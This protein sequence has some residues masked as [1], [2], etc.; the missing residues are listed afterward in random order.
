MVVAYKRNSNGTI[1]EL[2]RKEARG[3]AACHIS[4]HPFKSLAIVSN[5][6]SGNILSFSC[7]RMA[8]SVRYAMTGNIRGMEQM[9]SGKNSSI[10]ILR[11]WNRVGGMPQ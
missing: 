1:E 3:A 2:N 7:G 11:P 8:V 9:L 4:V 10:R 5:Y 6:V